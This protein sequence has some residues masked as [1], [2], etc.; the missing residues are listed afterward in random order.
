MGAEVPNPAIVE[1]QAVPQPVRDP[2]GSFVVKFI[3]PVY[4]ESYN[5]FLSLPKTDFQIS[6]GSGEI[7]FGV[8]HYTARIACGILTGNHFYHG[9]FSLDRKEAYNTSLGPENLLTEDKY[10]FIIPGCS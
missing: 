9:Y 3:H 1:T 8:P 7:T 4:S 6:Q 10:Y 5:C 2:Q